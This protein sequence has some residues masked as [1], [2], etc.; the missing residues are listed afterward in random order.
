MKTN[1]F[2]NDIRTDQTAKHILWLSI[3]FN[4]LAFAAAMAHNPPT[5]YTNDDFRMM[6]IVSGAY[7]GT[8]NADIVFMR[9]PVGL[10]LSGLYT[11]T[12]ALP[13]YG[14]FTML[15]MFLPSC[16]FCYY[17]VKKAYEKKLTVL[18][19]GLYILLFVFIIQKYICL[20]QFTM[21]S[22]FMGVGAMVLLFEMPEEKNSKQVI[23]ATVCAVVSFSVRSK[24]F[25]MLVPAILLIV[26]VRILR[27]RRKP[28]KYIVSCA[29]ML[30]LCAAVLVADA[31]AWSSADDRAFQAFKEARSEVYDY[32]SLP[33]YYE[34][35][36]FYTENRIS[37]VTYRAI[38]GRFL[39]ID[40]TVS[41]QTLEKIADYTDRVEKDG[42]HILA[43]IWEAFSDGMSQWFY[44]SDATVKYCAIFVT[45]LLF[46]AA[47]LCLVKRKPDVI[48][49]AL[50]AGML[51]EL[52][53]LQFLGRA[54]ARLLDLMLLS[55]AVIGCLTILELL[56]ERKTSF[57]A[58]KQWLSADRV[59]AASSLLSLCAV[60]VFIIAGVCNMQDDLDSKASSLRETTNTKLQA[61]MNYA[62]ADPNSFYFYDT[63]DFISCTAYVFQTF[64]E[65]TV[66]NNESLGSW[67]VRSPAYYKRNEKFSFT[68]AIDGLVSDTCDVYFVTASPPKMGITKTLK[69]L[70]NKKLVEVDTIQTAKD[71]LYVYMVA[72]DE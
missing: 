34:N 57:G 26:A 44:S 42:N 20:P 63:Y 21:T 17:I 65:D 18:G 51:L 43:R 30:L 59:R 70:C 22:A 62:A 55:M 6:T 19:I 11:L 38:S 25:Y 8:P 68:S 67:N 41:T 15:C 58:F 23:L 1:H 9:Y 4:A 64:A 12:A 3:V 7:T 47:A 5:W 61:L 49:P 60:G 32:A 72:D 40:E 52:T 16:L 28:A 29:G 2:S 14:L 37:E 46:A 45:A 50:V 39:D 27:D 33:G 69:A 35:I 13:W 71:I 54:M 36:S 24:A 31:A 53:Y 10:L 56:D 66:L 48:F